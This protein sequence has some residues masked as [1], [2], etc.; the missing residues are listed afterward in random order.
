MT[1]F[2]VFAKE[3]GML[4]YIL[5]IVL[6]IIKSIIDERRNQK[7]KIVDVERNDIKHPAEFDLRGVTMGCR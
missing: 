3:V 4:I 6:C 1:G 5:V 7:N 2:F